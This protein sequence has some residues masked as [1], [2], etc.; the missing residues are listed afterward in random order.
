MFNVEGKSLIG[1]PSRVQRRRQIGQRDQ[2]IRRVRAQACP[3]GSQDLFMQ[4]DGVVKSTGA[5]IG[6]REIVF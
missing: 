6:H 4:A 5:L 2:R 3:A 1:P